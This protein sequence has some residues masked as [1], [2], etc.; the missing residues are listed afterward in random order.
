[1]S[2]NIVNTGN[3]GTYMY[4]YIQQTLATTEGIM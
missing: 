1:M 2:E 4:M 3:K